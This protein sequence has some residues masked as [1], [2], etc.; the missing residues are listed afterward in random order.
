MRLGIHILPRRDE[1]VAGVDVK[2]TV[3]FVAM[4]VLCSAS[5]GALAEGGVLNPGM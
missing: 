2:H 1:H 4:R 3:I 5:S